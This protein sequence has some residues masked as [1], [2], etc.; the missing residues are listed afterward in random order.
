MAGG[1]T[2]LVWAPALGEA[3]CGDNGDACQ[4]QRGGQSGA[5]VCLEP[6][7]GQAQAAATREARCKLSTAPPGLRWRRYR[8]PDAPDFFQTVG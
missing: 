7:G 4:R 6:S 1:G 3:T 8:R 2:R 5:T